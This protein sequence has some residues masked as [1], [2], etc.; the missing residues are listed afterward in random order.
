[1]RLLRNTGYEDRI[2]VYELCHD[3]R[4]GRLIVGWAAQD[5][6][7]LAAGPG[8]ADGRRKQRH[9]EITGIQ[10]AAD[11]EPINSLTPKPPY[12]AAKAKRVLHIFCTARSAI[13]IRGT[14][15][16]SYGSETASRC[17]GS[18]NS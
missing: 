17:P 12:L 7:K 14:T 2:G 13:S 6:A 10:R 16:P 3:P 4:T 5:C 9:I 8:R 1:M 15:S 11:L 18:R